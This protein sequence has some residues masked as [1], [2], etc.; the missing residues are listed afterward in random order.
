MNEWVG[1]NVPPDTVE[2]I[3]GTAF[4]GKIAQIYNNKTKKL[5]FAESFNLYETQNTKTTYTYNCKNCQL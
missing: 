1:F 5:T 3:S 4:Q 2:V